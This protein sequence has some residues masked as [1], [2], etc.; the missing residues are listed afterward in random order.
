MVM[1]PLGNSL[2]SL[3]KQ[4]GKQFPLKTIIL[5]GLQIL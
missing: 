4:Y 2:E 3:F 1:K 5:I